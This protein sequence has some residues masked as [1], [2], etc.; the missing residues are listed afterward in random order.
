MFFLVI[1]L[2]VQSIYRLCRWII[3]IGE[4]GWTLLVGFSPFNHVFSITRLEPETCY[5]YYYYFP[6]EMRGLAPHALLCRPVLCWS[7]WFCLW[8]LFDSKLARLNF[9][10]RKNIG[11]VLLDGSINRLINLKSMCFC[12]WKHVQTAEY[13][14][15]MLV[16]FHLVVSSVT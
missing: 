13:K 12:L 4:P 11:V 7:L 3:F 9:L 1:I 6:L 16:V 2:L 8:W 14:P 5:Y 15:T 10:V